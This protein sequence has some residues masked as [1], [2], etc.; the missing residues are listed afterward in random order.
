MYERSLMGLC[1][2]KEVFTHEMG[3]LPFNTYQINNNQVGTALYRGF[4]QEAGV[5]P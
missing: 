2:L 5:L 1:T 3:F 4:P